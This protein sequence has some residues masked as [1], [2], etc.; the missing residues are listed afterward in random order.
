M[1]DLHSWS[2]QRRQEAPGEAQRQSLVEQAKGSHR[3][4]FRLRD[5]VSAVSGCAE[6][7]IGRERREIS[8]DRIR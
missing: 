5:V 7:V 6:V 4:R 1:Y 3:P 8:H 2:K